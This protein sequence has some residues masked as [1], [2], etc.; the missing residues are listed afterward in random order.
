[1]LI[2]IIILL[3]SACS[4]GKDTKKDKDKA[5]EEALKRDAET[6]M[7]ETKKTGLK[8]CDVKSESCAK[9]GDDCKKY[10]IATEPSDCKKPPRLKCV[11]PK[12]TICAWVPGSAGYGWGCLYK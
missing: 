11:C 4:K 6:V 5:K 2:L 12:R 7:N 3:L 8:I 9:G 1:M 10:A